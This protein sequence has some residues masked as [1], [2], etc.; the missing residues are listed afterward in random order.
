MKVEKAGKRMGTIQKNSSF[1]NLITTKKGNLGE[2][3]IIDLLEKKNW[4]C[5]QAITE[6]AHGF[7]IMASKNK[8]NLCIIEVKSKAK[9]TYYPDTGVDLRNYKKYVDVHLKYGIPFYIIFIDENMKKIYGN[10]IEKLSQK[11]SVIHNGKTLN[12]PLKQNGLIYF[13]M[14]NMVEICEITDECA[15]QL[16]QL[17]S[18]KYNYEY[19]NHRTIK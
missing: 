5:Y 4:I 2:R 11:T 9:R 8:S 15:D 3:I 6:K 17:S 16:K 19:N 7:D 14:K 18:R 10:T 12:Y 13:P 1:E